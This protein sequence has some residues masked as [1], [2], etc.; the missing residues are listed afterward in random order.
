MRMPTG[1]TA[2]LYE[3]EPQT[4][5]EF[6]LAVAHGMG[7]LIEMRDS[8][9]Y[10]PIPVFT[11]SEY[12]VQRV[13]DARAALDEVRDRDLEWWVRRQR[14][15]AERFRAEDA[16]AEERRA[17]LRGRYEAMLA[18]VEAWVPPTSEHVGLKEFMRSQLQ[19]SIEFD[20]QTLLT[21]PWRAVP[22]TVA[23]YRD[24][25]VQRREQ[26]LERA[27]E[28]LLEEEDSVRKRNAWVDALLVSLGVERAS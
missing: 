19:Q 23:E 11:V 4:F 12:A 28:A 2:K 8:S 7:A 25:V 20:A 13:A 26:E 21:T 27:G 17:A 5:E 6:A 24:H 10:A 1:Y 3:G 16:A 14:E 22:R 15:E 18:Q 9:M